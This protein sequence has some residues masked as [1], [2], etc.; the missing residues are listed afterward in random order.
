MEYD[1]TR[2]RFSHG[3]D[4]GLIV[5]GEVQQDPDTGE[6]VVVDEDGKGFSSQSLLKLLLG[7]RVRL[8]C[9]SFDAMED[10]QRILEA[11]QAREG[12][13]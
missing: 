3:F 8:T 7:K 9:I 10:A 12:A 13:S 4:A 11:A 5:D 6:F 1:N 2:D